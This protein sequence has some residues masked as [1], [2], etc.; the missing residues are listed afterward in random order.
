MTEPTRPSG[1]P[2]DL[3]IR[4]ILRRASPLSIASIVSA[5]IS[6]GV[7][8]LAARWVGPRRFGDV[9][10]ALLFWFYGALARTGIFEG[11]LREYIH[12]RSVGDHERARRARNIGVTVEFVVSA[13]PGLLIFFVALWADHSSLRRT[14][15]LLAPLGV[16][17]ASS[18]AFLGGLFM[19][20][21]RASELGIVS[22]GRAVV[23]AAV[24]LSGIPVL[25]APALLL[26]PITGDTVMLAALLTQYRRE[27]LRPMYTPSEAWELVK[28]GFPIGASSIVYWVY[29]LV[30]PT[31][32]AVR[33]QS[34][35]FGFYSFANAPV[36]IVSRALAQVYGI[37]MPA[38]W[39]QIAAT[40]G[41]DEWRRQAR[42]L[43]VSIVVIA[44]AAM[45]ACQ[46]GYGPA[47]SLVAKSFAPSIPIFEILAADI[48]ALAIPAV[49]SLVLTSTLAN[50]QALVLKLAL[51]SVA[52]N[53]V[54]NV[55]V[56]A[57]GHGA[58]AI[59]WNDVWIQLLM[60]FVTLECAARW[61]AP[62]RVRVALYARL[63]LVLLWTFAVS[64]TLHVVR[65]SAT[66]LADAL[67]LAALRLAIVGFLWCIPAGIWWRS[68]RVAQ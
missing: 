49:P 47:V 66:G 57:T 61:L 46:A 14:G 10:Y 5:G 60:A 6:I 50:R 54:A 29:R 40:P 44:G 38:L 35:V 11:A 23:V 30:G 53:V 18:A 16:L 34:R 4:A 39:G 25:G 27:R 17:V 3:G 2:S 52:L 28:T 48:V 36:A 45:N 1:A 62:D 31:S 51:A 33:L 15:L 68:R 55:A 64:L 58:L 37:L 8:L 63:V 9:Q 12:F 43:T 19:A 13:I 59:A 56:L 24:T 32:V 65:S 26:A 21:E 20:E 67:L 22:V 7:T 41:G 42:R